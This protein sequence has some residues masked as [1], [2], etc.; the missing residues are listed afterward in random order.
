MFDTVLGAKCQVRSGDD[1]VASKKTSCIL[2]REMKQGTENKLQKYLQ[3]V[4][5][6][7]KIVASWASRF[8]DGRLYKTNC[9]IPR[10]CSKASRV[11]RPEPEKT[12]M[13]TI[14]TL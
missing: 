12:L 8:K 13:T 10:G 4:K 5:R 11:I 14:R 2:M 7:V 1:F 6:L 9:S 3:L